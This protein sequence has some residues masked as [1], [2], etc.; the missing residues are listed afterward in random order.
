MEKRDRP[1]WDEY[2]AHET[3]WIATRSSCWHLQ[4][5]ARIVKD[6]HGIASGYNGAPKGIP[7][8]LEVGCRKEE[9]GVKFET[10]GMDVCRGAHAESNA[11]KRAS[12]EDLEGSTLY[13]LRYPCSTCTKE[14][15]QAGIIEVVYFKKY[16]EA[17]LSKELLAQ[18]GIKVRKIDWNL[19]QDVDLLRRLTE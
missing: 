18:A 1:T 8:C 12:K 11:I 10:K 7:N 3:W 6:N 13:T 15:I 17:K 4:S 5:G 19:D 16:S 9:K 2:F 14:I